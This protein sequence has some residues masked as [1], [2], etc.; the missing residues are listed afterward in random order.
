M[1]VSNVFVHHVFFW[2]KEADNKE[3]LK[4]LVAG[5]K[6]LSGSPAIDQFQIGKP[7]DTNRE[8]IERTYSV[9]WMLL[10]KTPEAQETYQVHPDH[11]EFVK[12]CAHLWSKV[13]VYDSVNME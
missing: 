13:V 4:Q 1:D 5:L 8:V 7:A 11:M 12:D 2:L 9:S 3:D 10:F 6:K